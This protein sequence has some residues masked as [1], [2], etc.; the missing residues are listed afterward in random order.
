M[1]KE[2]P[3]HLNA[4]VNI[5]YAYPVK[6]NEYGVYFLARFELPG[7]SQQVIDEIKIIIN[8]KFL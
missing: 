8:L 6:K 5:V 1:S 4:G 2:Q 3:Y 7:E